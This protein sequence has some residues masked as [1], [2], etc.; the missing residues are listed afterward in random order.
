MQWLGTMCFQ[1]QVVW[2]QSLVRE[3][4]ADKPHENPEIQP[5]WDI[6]LSSFHQTLSLYSETTSSQILRSGGPLESCLHTER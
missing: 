4:R 2:V 5:V 1:C 3:P 6:D